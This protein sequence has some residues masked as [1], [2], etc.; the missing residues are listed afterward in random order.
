MR[1]PGNATGGFRLREHGHG[2]DAQRSCAE[3]EARASTTQRHAIRPTCRTSEAGW[4]NGQRALHM[5]GTFGAG[6]EDCLDDWERSVGHIGSHDIN[7]ALRGTAEIGPSAD[8]T[9]K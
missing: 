4:L 6:R 7:T 1:S 2:E 8:A 5:A 3:L 9:A